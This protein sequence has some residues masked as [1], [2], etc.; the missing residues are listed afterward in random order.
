MVIQKVGLFD[1]PELHIWS[2]LIKMVMAEGIGKN[3]KAIF[4]SFGNLVGGFVRRHPLFFVIFLALI[5]YVLYQF[6]IS[7]DRMTFG[8]C[9]LIS[10]VSI[11]N[12]ARTKNYAETLMSFMLG[13]LT[14]FTIEWSSPRPLLF[15]SF[16]I[17]INLLLFIINSVQLATTLESELTTASSLISTEEFKTTYSQLNSIVHIDTKY[18]QLS[19]IEKASVV[20]H[21]SYLSVPMGEMTRSIAL[22]EMIK[23]VFQISLDDAIKFYRNI[24][25]VKQRA[26]QTFDPNQFLDQ[27]V[28]RRLPLTPE[29]F[30]MIFDS[31]KKLLISGRFTV[32]EYLSCLER[33]L[34]DGHSIAEIIDE[35][36]GLK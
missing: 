15:V 29:E 3:S 11:L 8:L 33:L 10:F 7:A 5:G 2:R 20:K 30:A 4:V 9:I 35:M 19:S 18:N 27:I 23:V 17:G 12:F 25:F 14:I 31:T 24:Y 36:N 1:Q 28:I 13:I 6:S 26:T 32:N 34:K 22:V 16:Y 21:L